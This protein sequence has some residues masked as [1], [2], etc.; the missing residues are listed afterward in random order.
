VQS[1]FVAAFAT[2]LVNAGQF[3]WALAV[4]MWALSI[5]ASLFCF[6]H[7]IAGRSGA[8]AAS[9]WRRYM[10]LIETGQ[11]EMPWKKFYE[12]CEAEHDNHG[13]VPPI[14]NVCSWLKN[15]CAR[16]QCDRCLLTRLPLPNA[17]ITTPAIFAM[18]WVIAS[19]YLTTRLF[20]AADPLAID[21]FLPLL[22]SRSISI[23]VLV[24]TVIILCCILCHYRI[25]WRTTVPETRLL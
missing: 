21:P 6:F 16:L 13:E 19:A 10:R 15:L 20:I 4:F 12:Y 2:L 5:G 18:G 8:R 1:I 7:H 14:R 25:W 11:A 17:W 23:V 3:P 22:C 24:F 9:K